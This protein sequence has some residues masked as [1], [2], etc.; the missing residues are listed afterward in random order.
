MSQS[1]LFELLSNGFIDSLW[2]ILGSTFIAYIFGFP[3]GVIITLTSKDGL[4]PKPVLSVSFNRVINIFR[5]IQF[6]I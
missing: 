6:Y 4:Y 5:S 3:L 2:I 1:Q